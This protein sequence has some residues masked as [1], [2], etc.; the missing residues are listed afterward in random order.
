[1]GLYFA[2]H[3]DGGGIGY[4]SSGMMWS[5]HW[6]GQIG[7][8]PGCNYMLPCGSTLGGGAGAA[9]GVASGVYTLVGSV[10]GFLCCIIIFV[11]GVACG[12][13]V[14]LKIAEICFRAAFF[15]PTRFVRGVVG[16]GLNRACIS[17]SAACISA[18]SVDNLGNG[19]VAGNN[20]VVLDT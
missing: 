10:E 12:G 8:I 3:F 1:M 9:S 14:V 11:V 5:A 6:G 18:P 15:L 16:V 20:S 2:F 4:M 13:L 17:S 7:A 19:R